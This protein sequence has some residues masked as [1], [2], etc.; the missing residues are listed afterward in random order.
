MQNQELVDLNERCSFYRK[1]MKQKVD[2]DKYKVQK[3]TY[4]D[5]VMV[6]QLTE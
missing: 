5:I 1:I 2:D 4:I 6:I 3:K